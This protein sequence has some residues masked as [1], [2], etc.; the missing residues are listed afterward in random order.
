MHNGKATSVIE[1]LFLGKKNFFCFFL[2]R[3]YGRYHLRGYRVIAYGKSLPNCVIQIIFLKLLLSGDLI[4]KYL[5]IPFTYFSQIFP[6]L[7]TPQW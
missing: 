3:G 4:C 7:I 6:H 1:M 5:Q 2:Y